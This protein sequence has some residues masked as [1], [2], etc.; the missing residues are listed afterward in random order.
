MEKA[1]IFVLSEVIHKRW[2]GVMNKFAVKGTGYPAQFSD[3]SFTCE[4]VACNMLGHGRFSG[5]ALDRILPSGFIGHGHGLRCRRRKPWKDLLRVQ[6]SF[7]RRPSA[8]QKSFPKW[9]DS[10]VTFLKRWNRHFND[11]KP[12]II[13]QLLSNLYSFTANFGAFNV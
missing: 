6:C 8:P 13:S 10:K 5:L 7:V 3:L 2:S 11:R 12:L 1:P 4:K 9:V